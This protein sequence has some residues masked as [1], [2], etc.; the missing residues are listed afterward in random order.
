MEGQFFAI[1][2]NRGIF[3]DALK[4]NE[5]NF[6]CPFLRGSKYLFVGIDAA[7][8][9]TM[10]AVGG[11]RAALFGNLRIVGKINML[12]VADPVLGD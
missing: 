1:E 5:D 7:G 2:G 10:A 4:L 12:A 8:E 6:F 3:V 11:I 9:I